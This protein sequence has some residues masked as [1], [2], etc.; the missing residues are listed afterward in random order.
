MKKGLKRL[1][2][3]KYNLDD[4]FKRVEE[5]SIIFLRLYINALD[6]AVRAM[7]ESNVRG[8]IKWTWNSIEY[9][10]KYLSAVHVREL[11][12]VLKRKI[13]NSYRDKNIDVDEETIV[14]SIVPRLH[15][16]IRPRAR[17]LEEIKPELKGLYETVLWA[18]AL[19][20]AL[21]EGYED[22]IEIKDIAIRVL[23]QIQALSK[24]I[25]LF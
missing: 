21:Q 13:I 6:N 14:E 5:N 22:E 25:H 4:L 17:V 20:L 8:L 10:V 18:E 16:S 23:S 1:V 15:K 24:K 12:R 7:A 19:F 2:K 9:L 3:S 11:Y